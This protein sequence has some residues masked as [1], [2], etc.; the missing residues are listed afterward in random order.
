MRDATLVFI[1]NKARSYKKKKLLTLRAKVI[2]SSRVFSKH[3]LQ[4]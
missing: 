4:I 2:T 1:V 3:T